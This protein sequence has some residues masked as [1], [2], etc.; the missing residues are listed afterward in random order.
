MIQKTN[1]ISLYKKL[2]SELEDKIGIRVEGPIFS[3]TIDKESRYID[4]DS[5]HKNYVRIN[6]YDPIWS[7]N[8]NELTVNQTIIFE[9]PNYLYGEEG[10]TLHGNT[11]GLAVHIHSKDSN[12]QQTLPVDIIR[13][14]TDEIKITFSYTFEPS[15]LKNSVSL[16]FFLYLKDYSYPYFKHANHIGMILSEDYLTKIEIIVDGDGS[17]FPMSEFSNTKGPLWELKNNWVEASIETFDSSTVNLSLNTAHPL[18]KQIK[19][20]KTPISRALMGDIM[21]QAMSMIINQVVIVEENELS[22]DT[23]VQADSILEAV[24]YWISSFEIDVTSSFSITN[25]MRSYWDRQ[26]IS[27]GKID[28]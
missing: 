26:M 23:D 21:V 1:Q 8:D 6:D 17:D 27:G 18:F 5:E 20:G 22:H 11:I 16:D 10:V 9:R 4:T 24:K 19:D 3:Y 13:N 2:N 12:F 7:P 15:T 25:S 28:D 14:V